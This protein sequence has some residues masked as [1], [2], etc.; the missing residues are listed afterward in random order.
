VPSNTTLLRVDLRRSTA[1]AWPPSAI[2]LCC[3]SSKSVPETRRPPTVLKVWQSD[4]ADQLPDL[5]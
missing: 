5:L 3:V 2:L 4:F 1:R